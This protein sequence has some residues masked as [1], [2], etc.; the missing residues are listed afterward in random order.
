MDIE[1]ERVG[2]IQ[3]RGRVRERQK[4]GKRAA[5]IEISALVCVS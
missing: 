3:G 5:I 2:E 1:R 4:W